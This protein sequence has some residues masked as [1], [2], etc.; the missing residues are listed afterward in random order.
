MIH[1]G[2]FELELFP[3]IPT[4]P[5]AYPREWRDEVLEAVREAFA[6]L[7]G[8]ALLVGADPINA[9][10]GFKRIGRRGRR[11]ISQAGSDEYKSASL[12][13]R[14]VLHPRIKDSVYF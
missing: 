5:T 8:Q 12:L 11:L 14:N 13:P 4:A 1:P 7:D 10:N 9:R 2:N 6:W 3:S